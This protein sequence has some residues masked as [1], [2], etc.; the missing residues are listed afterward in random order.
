MFAN[1]EESI[2]EV[3]PVIS[4]ALFSAVAGKS[5]FRAFHE[6]GLIF[7]CVASEAC[8]FLSHRFGFLTKNTST[9]T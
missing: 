6:S 7:H 3:V 8:S 5:A 9:R 4:L 1:K 2:V